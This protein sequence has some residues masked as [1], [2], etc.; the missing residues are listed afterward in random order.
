M[1]VG[2]L[3]STFVFPGKG[4]FDIYRLGKLQDGTS[5]MDYVK[6]F[7][8]DDP[9]SYAIQQYLS[10]DTSTYVY[11]LGLVQPIFDAARIR[12]LQTNPSLA[13]VKFNF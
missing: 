13:I 12:L 11:R 10:D 8:F 6:R 9:T 7:E 2:G 1:Q 5:T 3:N 4:Y